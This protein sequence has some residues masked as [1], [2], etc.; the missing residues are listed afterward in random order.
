MEST[1]IE[2]QLVKDRRNALLGM[3]GCHTPDYDD[4][5]FSFS[6]EDTLDYCLVPRS[7][8][9]YGMALRL[10][11]LTIYTDEEMDSIAGRIVSEQ[12]RWTS[13]WRLMCQDD[14]AR[15]RHS[16]LAV[17][18]QEAK[19]KEARL[20]ELLL[21]SPVRSPLPPFKEWQSPIPVWQMEENN[22]EWDYDD[23]KRRPYEDLERL[24]ILHSPD[25]FCYER[26]DETMPEEEEQD[27]IDTQPYEI[28]CAQRKVAEG[29]RD[30]DTEE[31]EEDEEEES[32]TAL[33]LLH[34]DYCNR[35]EARELSRRQL[36]A[37]LQAANNITAL[38]DRTIARDG[39][40]GI[41]LVNRMRQLEH[42]HSCKLWAYNIADA[43]VKTFEDYMDA[44]EEKESDQLLQ[45]SLARAT[46]NMLRRDR[47]KRSYDEMKAEEEESFGFYRD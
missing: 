4:N 16:L 19:E 20:R 26:D 43:E 37:A 46:V 6:P 1:Q 27:A 47:N 35:L 36:T 39:G 33:D 25:L 21:S 23:Q 9:E 45:R 34:V 3:P 40:I 13:S 10:D 42:E 24:P 38:V 5:V 44:R 11:A 29:P 28:P 7:K 2:S 8:Q 17:T 32:T 22:N 15:V 14:A 41:E 18:R 30:S 12:L 31:E